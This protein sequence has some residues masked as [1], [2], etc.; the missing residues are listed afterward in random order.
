MPDTMSTPTSPKTTGRASQTT[1]THGR[2]MS[3]AETAPTRA[4][5]ATSGSVTS[6]RNGKLVHQ[7]PVGLKRGLSFLFVLVAGVLLLHTTP[8][9]TQ[10]P[11]REMYI[12]LLHQTGAARRQQLRHLISLEKKLGYQRTS[13]AADLQSGSYL[14]PPTNG[15]VVA[16]T[17]TASD[18]THSS[19]DDQSAVAPPLDTKASAAVPPPLFKF[20]AVTP[21]LV[22]PPPVA[23]PPN[24]EPAVA[25]PPPEVKS[26][27]PPVPDAASAPPPVMN[28][29]AAN[30]SPVADEPSNPTTF[31][32]SNQ[33][34]G[35]VAQYP[36]PKPEPKDVIMTMI[37][38]NS[39]ARHAIALV[40]SLRDVN[41]QADAIIVL[42]QQGGPGSPECSNCALRLLLLPADLASIIV[43]RVIVA[44]A[45]L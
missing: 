12:K 14:P 7:A 45:R 19:P 40:Q 18:A 10:K 17:P 25:S 38:G 26:D 30:S 35:I 16:T 27:L 29:A 34:G 11:I 41:T 32:V 1:S 37:A 36:T 39:A 23:P 44:V 9:S 24:V 13:V 21:P 33:A 3:S 31:Y 20:V 6:P 4:R 43:P 5:A 8:E 42:I 22:V 28:A 15:G 2:S